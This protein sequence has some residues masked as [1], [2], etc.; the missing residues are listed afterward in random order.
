MRDPFWPFL[1]ACAVITGIACWALGPA[2]GQDGHMRYHQYYKDWKQPGLDLSCCN[3]RII[4]LN[5]QDLT[6]DC[7]PTRAEIRNGQWFFWQCRHCAIL[8]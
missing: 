3:A 4:D 6:G 2:K 5:G 1:L 8:P 7:E